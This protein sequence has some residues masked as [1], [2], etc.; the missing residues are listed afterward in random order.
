[1][2]RDLSIG[3]NGT[4]WKVKIRRPKLLLY[5]FVHVSV[6][7]RPMSRPAF[8]KGGYYLHGP[9]ARIASRIIDY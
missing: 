9:I 2:Y 8:A 7:F 1:M 3:R 4:E 6:I 5:V